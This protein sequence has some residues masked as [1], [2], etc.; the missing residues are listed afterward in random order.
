MKES[1]QFVY[2]PD[3]VAVPETHERLLQGK[4]V[5]LTGASRG[6]GAAIAVEL[7]KQG[8]II[9]GPHRD[10]GKEKRSQE[11][12]KK[13]GEAGGKMYS[14]VTDITNPNDQIMLGTVVD[15]AYGGVDII[16][17][18][19]AGGMESWA[20]EDYANNINAH[21]KV[22]LT[23]EFADP[24]VLTHMRKV[25]KVIDI[26]SLWTLLYGKVTQL[27]SYELVAKSKK[28]GDDLL[29]ETIEDINKKVEEKI[30]YASVCGHAID[31][32]TT[33]KLMQRQYPEEMAEVIK[34]AEGGLLPTIDDMAKA[35]AK[36]AAT[37][38]ED[39][40]IEFVGCPN[41]SKDQVRAA[42][43][44]YDE[45]TRY[46]D[47]AVFFD[48]KTGFGYLT[49]KKDHCVAHFPIDEEPLNIEKMSMG[50]ASCSLRIEDRYT[51]GHFTKETDISLFPGHKM[52][53]TL[54]NCVELHELLH[55]N[56]G[57]HDEV[58]LT[59]ISGVVHF[60]QPVVPGDKLLINGAITQ[61]T[62]DGIRVDGQFFV[63]G[64]K[65]A[66]AQAVTFKIDKNS[67]KKE[68]IT[69]DR[70]I[71]AAAQTLGLSFMHQQEK[72]E[73]VP[74]FKAIEGP[75]EF[76]RNIQP[77]EVLEFQSFITIN[78]VSGDGFKG[79]VMVRVGNEVVATIQGIDCGIIK[80]RELAKRLIQ[81]AVNRRR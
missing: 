56:L 8:A 39:G 78:P 59:G 11:V 71:E 23:Q 64:A 37:D 53:A 17:H 13:V 35:V 32:T 4:V 26:T 36:L 27:P 62:S 49:V 5:L 29:K 55:N 43:S 73:A 50:N 31:G 63:N 68:Y 79:N 80:D 38:F 30:T 19:A 9:I 3:Q 45:T 14:M 46:I 48:N 66:E 24:D 67:D 58:R 51:Q 18:N 54:G 10:E 7:A 69:P 16:I 25:K 20:T 81:R 12:A 77:G 44:M 65:V 28:L 74:V 47:R 52:I 57:V 60:I 22:A 6:I 41:W 40:H 34:T 42:L 21:A 70:I 33:I 76:L 15:M 61:E 72:A 1:E 2:A 75:C